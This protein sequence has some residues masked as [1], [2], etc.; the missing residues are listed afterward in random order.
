V[1]IINPL[2]EKCPQLPYHLKKVQDE[3][4]LYQENLALIEKALKKK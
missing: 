2:L 4:K 3:V 1:W